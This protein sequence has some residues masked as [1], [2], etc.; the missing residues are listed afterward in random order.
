MHGAVRH[1]VVVYVPDVFL[2][3]SWGLTGGAKRSR[4]SAQRRAYSWHCRLWRAL[5]SFRAWELKEMEM[6]SAVRWTLSIW[7]PSPTGGPTES[8]GPR[9]T[10]SAGTCLRP[11][12][13]WAH[14][15][16]RSMAV[17]RTDRC[18]SGCRLCGP[19]GCAGDG[20][21]GP[22]R[23]SAPPSSGKGPVRCR[24]G[25]AASDGRH[26]AAEAVGTEPRS[27]PPPLFSP[28]YQVSAANRPVTSVP[29]TGYGEP[30]AITSA[31]SRVCSSGMSV[32]R[33][34]GGGTRAGGRRPP[35]LSARCDRR[36]C[37]TRATAAQ[38]LI[39]VARQVVVQDGAVQAHPLARFT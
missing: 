26:D 37:A 21:R 39:E 7:K 13:R 34:P 14:T 31:R 19:S 28:A 17:P 20:N 6:F 22:G 30:R 27:S 33:L 16:S 32:N 5:A 23:R 24:A 12:R 3:S 11:P 1:R 38:V 35:T 25:A 10:P 36:G 29:A 8:G 18:T 2:M 9:Q 4:I 15:T